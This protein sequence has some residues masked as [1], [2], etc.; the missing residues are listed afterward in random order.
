MDIGMIAL[1]LGVREAAACLRLSKET[2]VT[3]LK[4]C[5]GVKRL[6]E[7]L[8]ELTRT[9]GIQKTSALFGLEKHWLHKL[10]AFEE[11]LRVLP[12]KRTAN[13]ASKHRSSFDETPREAD[14]GCEEWF[15]AERPRPVLN[16]QPIHSIVSASLLKFEEKSDS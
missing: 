4:Q 6:R 9:V 5:Q 10:N 8:Q 2:V 7:L 3:E 1:F 16:S 14:I 12:A 13:C 11:D 15:D